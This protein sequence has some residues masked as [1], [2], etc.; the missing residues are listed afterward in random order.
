MIRS[1][2]FHNFLSIVLFFFIGL[3]LRNYFK[4]K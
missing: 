3:S 1:C 2:P 4:I